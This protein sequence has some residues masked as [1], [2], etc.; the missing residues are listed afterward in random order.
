MSAVTNIIKYFYIRNFFNYI[1]SRFIILLLT[2]YYDSDQI[3]E[4]MLGR[5][6]SMHGRDARFIQNFTSKPDWKTLFQ[7]L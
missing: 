2:K 5:A 1:T 6:H 3:T 7:D 4:G